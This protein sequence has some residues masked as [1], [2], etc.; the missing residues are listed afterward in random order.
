MTAGNLKNKLSLLL[1]VLFLLF[2]ATACIPEATSVF[3]SMAQPG[4]TADGVDY[5]KNDI[6]VAEYDGGTNTASGWLTAFDGEWYGL[7]DKG[8]N[9]AAF[10]FNEMVIPL[11][12]I[13]SAEP[14]SAAGTEME[15]FLTF[16][17]N[18]ARVPGVTDFIYG[19]DIAKFNVASPELFSPVDADYSYEMF[20]DGSD[21]GLTTATEKL[22][23]ISVWT[24]EYYDF[25]SSNVEMPFDCHAAVIFLSTRGNYRVS[26]T[27]EG[28]ALVGGGSDVLAFCA[29]NTG[30]DT[31][32]F[33][34]RVF[35]SDDAGIWPHQTITS[36]DV[37]MLDYTVNPN[38]VGET[39]ETSIGFFFTPRRPFTGNGGA[40]TGGTSDLFVGVSDGVNSGVE[41][42]YLNFNDDSN[43]NTLPAVNGVVEG[44]GIFDFPFTSVP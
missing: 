44:I 17:Q 12:L 39:L 9:L 5:D 14:N 27:P 38:S 22:D 10:S 18:R 4:T 19:Q 30:A 29:T 37:W 23:G 25:F 20:F 16:E 41:G 13:V 7:T 33:W 1:V 28:N 36:L 11:D 21:V 43:N 3:V 31:A 26:P 42:P 2:T 34:F 8:H 35:D 15:I 24:P 32:G 40:V 6:L